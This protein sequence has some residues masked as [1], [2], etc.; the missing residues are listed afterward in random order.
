MQGFEFAHPNIYPI[1]EVLVHV[2]GRVGPA[3]P[4]L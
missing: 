4:K 2:K 3:D 1:Y